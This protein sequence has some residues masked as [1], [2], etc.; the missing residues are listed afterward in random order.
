M[1]D[2]EEHVVDFY[3]R[4]PISADHILA[5]LK[6]DR[7]DLNNVRPEELYAHDQDH[8]G[9]LDA[10]EALAHATRMGAGKKIADFCAGLAGPARYWAARYG[11][12]VT[13]IELTANRTE[14]AN[15]LTRLVGL[16]AQVRVLQGD[17]LNCSLP[18]GSFDAVVSQ[19]AFL[20]VP[21]K[22]TAI[23]QA[24]RIL[25]PGG[26]LAF[27]DWIIHRPLQDADAEEMWQGIA[28]QTLQTIS[29]YKALLSDAGFVGIAAEDQTAAWA[30]ILEKRFAMF[31][32]L[33]E[34]ARRTGSPSGD[35]TFY[36]S[37]RRLV[38]L[39]K[40]RTL[41]GVRMSAEKPA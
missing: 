25:K 36:H 40:E 17:V 12:D 3:R 23:G 10:N 19:E 32:E 30:D 33:R 39:V 27:S 41:G 15:Q 37:Y 38:D 16:E 22:S 5:K 4:H 1:Q 28:A 18:S 14:G 20:H 9:G 21:D 2:R 31:T 11:V 24:F 8:Y 13:G 35:D 26:R 6:A 34:E 29:G 7:G